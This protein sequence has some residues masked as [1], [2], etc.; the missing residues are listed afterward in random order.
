MKSDHPHIIACLDN[1]EALNGLSHSDQESVIA[2]VL[3]NNDWRVGFNVIHN[4]NEMLCWDIKNALRGFREMKYDSI[5]K[6]GP[7]D[8]EIAVLRHYIKKSPPYEVFTVLRSIS[9]PAKYSKDEA[10]S[11]KTLFTDLFG[12]EEA[13]KAFK[14]YPEEDNTFSA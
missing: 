11:K 8:L 3:E 9:I 2:Y 10:Y 5:T 4:L 14:W 7:F 6:P 12:M 1:I 13:K